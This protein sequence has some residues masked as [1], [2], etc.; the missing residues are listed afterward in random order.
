MNC[1]EPLRY[2]RL[3]GYGIPSS[4]SL[5]LK[6]ADVITGGLLAPELLDVEVLSVLRRAVLRRELTE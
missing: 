6:F 4:D 5:G 3:R 2:R 1:R